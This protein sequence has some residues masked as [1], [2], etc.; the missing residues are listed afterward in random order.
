MKCCM[1]YS[2]CLN[3]SMFCNQ[4]HKIHIDLRNCKF[5]KGMYYNNSYCRTRD[6]QMMLLCYTSNMLLNY[7]KLH[8]KQGKQHSY[9]LHQ[10]MFQ[11]D[12]QSSTNYLKGILLL[13]L[14]SSS[15]KLSFNQLDKFNKV[16]YKQR[17]ESYFNLHNL[18][19]MS[20]CCLCKTLW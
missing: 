6:S 3:L 11:Q 4:N 1:M 18:S 9:C 15:D 12:K 19:C 13:K 2:Q 20:M 16:M 7:Y 10:G 8:I 14:K 5:L 17:M